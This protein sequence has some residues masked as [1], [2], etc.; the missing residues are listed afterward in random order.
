[1]HRGR[2]DAGGT[3]ARWHA[4][5]HRRSTTPRGSWTSSGRF[6]LHV[7]R[8]PICRAAGA[9]R[10]ACGA[11]SAILPLASGTRP[12]TCQELRR[13]AVAGAHPS[14]AA[15]RSGGGGGATTRAAGARWSCET[16]RGASA[17]WP[18]ARGF[19][20]RGRGGPQ[21][22]TGGPHPSPRHC[23]LQAHAG[24]AGQAACW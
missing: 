23:P 24:A 14:D 20:A 19:A 22:Q 3:R 2:D 21:Q 5:P 12:S 7:L 10:R 17:G 13:P 8:T 11:T 6:R 4:W 1:M 15:N 9:G 18:R 16:P